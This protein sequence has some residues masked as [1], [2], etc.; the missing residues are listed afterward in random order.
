MIKRELPFR[1]EGRRVQEDFLLW[2]QIAASGAPCYVLDA[3]LAF[4][5]RPEFDPGG[6]GGDLWASE[7]RVIAALARLREGSHLSLIEWLLSIS[8]SLIMY[9]RRLI[10]RH[11]RKL[12]SIR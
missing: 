4:S 5:F 2:A 9:A 11:L 10:M 3:T 6:Y 12:K 1:F 8:W 7:L